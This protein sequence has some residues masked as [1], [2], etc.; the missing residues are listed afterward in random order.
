MIEKVSMMDAQAKILIKSFE[1]TILY[2]KKR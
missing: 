1:K 2:K